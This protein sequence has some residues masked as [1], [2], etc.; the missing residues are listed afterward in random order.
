[1]S[2]ETVASRMSIKRTV[3]R[4]ASWSWAGMATNMVAGF[5][6][7]PFLV[8]QLGDTDYGLWIVI[9]SS[10]SGLHAG[11]AFAAERRRVLQ[12]ASIRKAATADL[13]SLA[14]LG[15]AG[16]GRL[17]S[18]SPAVMTRSSR[19][20]PGRG[21]SRVELALVASTC[22]GCRRTCSTPPRLAW[23]FDL[24]S[25]DIISV[26]IRTALTF[27]LIGNGYGIVTLAW[28][29][30]ITLAGGRRGAKDDSQLPA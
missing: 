17:V 12:V 14:I 28:L 15:G 21:R 3:V 23:R 11:L 27:A 25:V 16:Y 7:T 5:V 22:C 4:N 13:P 1:M 8:R 6:T 19:D 18:C 29:N 20:P 24:I 10:A 9:A 26:A 2:P 30:M